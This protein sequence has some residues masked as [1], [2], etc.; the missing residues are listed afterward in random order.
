MDTVLHSRRRSKQFLSQ[1]KTPSTSLRINVVKN[2]LLFKPCYLPCATGAN[3][4]ERL[5]ARD[6]KVEAVDDMLAIQGKVDVTKLDFS[7]RRGRTSILA[8]CRTRSSGRLSRNW[9]AILVSMKRL[10]TEKSSRDRWVPSGI[11]NLAKVA[12]IM[13]SKPMARHL[14]S[15]TTCSGTTQQPT[16]VQGARLPRAWATR[17]MHLKFIRGR[18]LRK[19]VS[20]GTIE[21]ST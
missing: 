7:E 16:Q 18:T 12:G 17:R 14:Q 9:I 10:A 5:T 19:C 13:P 15:C 11:G 1:D 6:A 2:K 4:C 3:N 8:V 21:V 20:D